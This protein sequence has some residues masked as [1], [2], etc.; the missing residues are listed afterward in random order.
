[1]R[2]N[3]L[4]RRIDCFIEC[5]L[6]KMWVFYSI[7]FLIYST[8]IIMH[9]FFYVTEIGAAS[10]NDPIMFKTIFEF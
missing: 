4:K 10:A 9:A 1:M 5:K 3:N 2:E 7:S 8:H 6:F